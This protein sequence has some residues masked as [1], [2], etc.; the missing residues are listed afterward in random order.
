M[1]EPAG[2]TTR[3]VGH[4]WVRER[5]A[6]YVAYTWP[7]PSSLEIRTSAE[8]VHPGDKV[9]VHVRSPWPELRTGVLTIARAGIREHRALQFTDGDAV[10][11]LTADDSW[12][13]TI[14]FNAAAVRLRVKNLP[15]LE[16]A[17]ATIEQAA[18]HR[19]LKVAVD[20][21]LEAGPGDEVAV[22][23]TVRDAAGD[24]SAARI[25]F[26]AVDEAVGFYRR[27][28]EEKEATLSRIMRESAERFNHSTTAAA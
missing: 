27:S 28:Y 22:E 11:E 14:Y 23:V 20:A 26:W 4:F 18:E 9:Q 12:T 6:G 8:E 15:K 7:R 17:R 10:V 5:P 1:R 2:H 13:P 3:S 24:P 19:R 25:A 16:T 21:P